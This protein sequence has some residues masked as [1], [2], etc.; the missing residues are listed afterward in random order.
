MKQ[1]TGGAMNATA[2]AIQLV[3]AQWHVA[4]WQKL[5][6]GVDE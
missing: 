3:I 4:G 5:V 1:S 6:R 2:R